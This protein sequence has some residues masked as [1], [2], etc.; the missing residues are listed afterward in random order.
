MNHV[1]PL[2][3]VRQP[4]YEV[5]KK[6]AE[7]LFNRLKREENFGLVEIMLKTLLILRESA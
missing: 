1:V 2:T 3:T 7:L 5:G 6:S 4:I